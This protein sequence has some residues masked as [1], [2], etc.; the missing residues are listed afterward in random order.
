[1]LEFNPFQETF[2]GQ[3]LHV[4]VKRFETARAQQRSRGPSCSIMPEE[5][6]YVP[7]K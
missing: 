1:M 7:S 2:V 3:E 5:A 4:V 6:H